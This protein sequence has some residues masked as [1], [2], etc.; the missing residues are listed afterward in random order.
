MTDGKLR[1]YKGSDTLLEL[2][3]ERPLTNKLTG[4][5]ITSGTVTATIHKESDGAQIG[6]TVTLTHQ[7]SPDGFWSGPIADDFA[8]FTDREPLVFKITA[9]GGAGLMLYK[10]VKGIVEVAS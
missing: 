5:A 7:G 10:E 8:T 3:A 9:D 4:A 6:G 1:V 2:G